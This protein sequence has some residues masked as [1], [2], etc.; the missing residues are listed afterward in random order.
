MRRFDPD[1]TAMIRSN[2]RES[3]IYRAD[4]AE[5]LRGAHAAL[6]AS[7]L[8]ADESLLYLLYS[9]IWEGDEARFGVRGEPASHAVAVTDRRFVVS[10]DLHTAGAE[11][12][13]CDIPF[14]RVLCINLGIALLMGWFSVRFARGGKPHC[15]SLLFKSS[16]FDHFAAAARTYRSR[17]GGD[18]RWGRVD[19]HPPPAGAS[20]SRADPVRGVL[21]QVM[22]EGER[23]ACEVRHQARWIREKRRWKEVSRGLVGEGVLVLTRRGLLYAS[24]EPD[25]AEDLWSYGRNVLVMPSEAVV[26]A[27]IVTKSEH[28]LSIGHLRLTLARGSASVEIDVPFDDSPTAGAREIAARLNRRRQQAG[29]KCG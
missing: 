19:S 23:P 9:P 1:D 22:L 25:T 12:T 15:L 26:S 7:A 16:G 29:E 11:P 20:S 8:P 27:R 3:F 10:R 4:G 24:S 5:E 28:R 2:G 18:P 14:D 6:V 21:C 17:C 13:V